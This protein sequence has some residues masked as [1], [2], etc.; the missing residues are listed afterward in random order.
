MKFRWSPR[1]SLQ[2]LVAPTKATF[3][4]RAFERIGSK[5]E[6]VRAISVISG[7]DEGVLLHE[8][9]LDR[10]FIATKVSWAANRKTP[11]IE[12]VAY[13]LLGIFGINMAMLYGEGDRAFIRL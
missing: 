11:K 7:I 13:S 3:Y 5:I 12:D 1:G 6:L 2:E 9:S 8:L 4:N 10:V